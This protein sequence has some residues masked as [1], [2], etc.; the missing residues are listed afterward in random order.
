MIQRL[1]SF[2]LSLSKHE[3]FKSL[4]TDFSIHPSTS[5]G[6]TEKSVSKVLVIGCAVPKGHKRN[7][8]HLSSFTLYRSHAPR[9]NAVSN[10]PALRFTS[11][12]RWSVRL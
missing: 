3:W 2:V 10:A 12:Q 11:K 4:L 6:R 9:G 8:V 5:S 7:E 1:R